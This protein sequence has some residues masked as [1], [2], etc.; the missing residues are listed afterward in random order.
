MNE[1]KKIELITRVKCPELRC[2]QPRVGVVVPVICWE[3]DISS[4]DAIV[5]SHEVY[6]AAIREDAHVHISIRG[7]HALYDA[8]IFLAGLRGVCNIQ[9]SLRIIVCIRVAVSVRIGGIV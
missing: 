1:I 5:E 6:V 4:I 2:V 3:S 7:V 9:C 8:A